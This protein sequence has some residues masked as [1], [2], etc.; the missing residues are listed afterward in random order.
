MHLM[1]SQAKPAWTPLLAALMLVAASGSQQ[2]AGAGAAERAEKRVACNN[3]ECLSLRE[4]DGD[5]T[6]GSTAHSENSAFG[7]PATGPGSADGAADDVG[8]EL[9][10]SR[11]HRRSLRAKNDASLPFRMHQLY[12]DGCI[13][14][15]AGNAVVRHRPQACSLVLKRF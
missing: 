5:M 12:T 1:T 11:A 14:S 9:L 10:A 6:A 4:N 3:A 8:P 15:R 2:S 13:L 7:V